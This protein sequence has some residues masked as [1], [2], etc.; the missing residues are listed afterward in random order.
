MEGGLFKTA[1]VEATF[2]GIDKE[3][4]VGGGI[5]SDVSKMANFTDC[6]F[7]TM[8][9]GVIKKKDFV[10]GGIDGVIILGK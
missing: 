4:V 8:D 6:V 7:V 5:E 10:G 9:D 3:K 1:F 2:G